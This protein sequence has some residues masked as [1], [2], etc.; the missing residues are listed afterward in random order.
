MMLG[1]ARADV[2]TEDAFEQALAAHRPKLLRHCYRMMGSFADAE[3]ELQE[4]LARAWSGRASFAGEAPLEHWLMRIAT[5]TCL[6]AL[7]K[8]KRRALPELAAR[9][10]P[11][12]AAIGDPIDPAAW[13][14]PA[15]D[16]RLAPAGFPSAADALE[17]RERVSLAFIALLQRLP[18]RQR[19]VLLLK[20]VLGFSSEE[21]AAALALSVAA[22]S[23]ALHRARASMPEVPA[24][25]E[26]P[27]TKLAELVRCWESRDVDGLLALLK[28]D[29]VFTM[30]PWAMWFRGRA[31]VA[32]FFENPRFTAFWSSGIELATTRA[33]GQ[34][35]LVFYRDGG[36][37]LHSL[38]LL[39]WDGHAFA[40]MVTFIGPRYLDGFSVARALK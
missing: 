18:P 37:T 25:V 22:V 16:E 15:P 12:G 2:A 6:N 13:I 3:D 28:D 5:N 40:E 35:A 38:Q 20:D 39:R 29:V 11:A 26:P 36:R 19:A 1:M 31:A 10:S 30:P 21:I 33:N 9:P 4:A 23:S 27:P 17:T 24:P 8:K 14:T 32:R 34:P 7:E